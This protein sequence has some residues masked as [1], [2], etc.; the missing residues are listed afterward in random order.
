VP[1]R[2]FAIAASGHGAPA[3]RPSAA[4]TKKQPA[5]A[6]AFAHRRQ[7]GSGEQTLSLQRKP[8]AEKIAA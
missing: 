7:I 5:A 2:L 4:A 3:S 6:F 1:G 8:I